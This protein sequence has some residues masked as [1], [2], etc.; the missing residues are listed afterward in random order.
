[1]SKLL[2]GLFSRP[3][4]KASG[5]VFGAG[6]TARGKQVTVREY[7]IPADPR[8]NAQIIQ[9]GKMP[10][11]T[12]IIQRIGRGVYQTA[13]NR[14]VKALPGFQSLSSILM[15]HISSDGEITSVP[16]QTSLGSLHA[17]LTVTP[18]TAGIESSVTFSTET[19]DL[20]SAAD[21]V[22][23]FAFSVDAP[24]DQNPRAVG[25]TL[26]PG[27]TRSDGSVEV[28]LSS[29]PV[30]DVILCFWFYSDAVGIPSHHRYSPATWVLLESD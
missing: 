13:W 29:A 26:D 14:A 1:M 21:Q 11:S 8:T 4:G 25:V 17:P 22:Q 10:F 15:Q 23:A 12:E 28:E 18:G 2:G 19:G 30:G 3:S 9:R 16:Q 24:T 7:V 5:L 20:G 27:A 6:R